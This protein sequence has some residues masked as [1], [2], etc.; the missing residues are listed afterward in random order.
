MEIDACVKSKPNFHPVY[1]PKDSLE[2]GNPL[3]DKSP[4]ACCR[5]TW[6]EGNQTWCKMGIWWN[7]VRTIYV[8]I[9]S[10][11]KEYTEAHHTGHV[12]TYAIRVSCSISS[13]CT[14]FETHRRSYTNC[15][16]WDWLIGHEKSCVTWMWM[17]VS[18]SD[19][20]IHAQHDMGHKI[21]FGNTFTLLMKDI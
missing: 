16:L 11:I 18:N 6:Y 10:M 9:H 17:Q 19:T 2:S 21:G 20:W 4:R 12:Y 3:E 5:Q 7:F 14:H 15:L 1:F 8:H 13:P